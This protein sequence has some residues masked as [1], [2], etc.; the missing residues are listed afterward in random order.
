MNTQ[1]ILNEVD[2]LHASAKSGTVK[3][4]NIQYRLNFNGNNYDV[5]KVTGMTGGVVFVTFNTRS[6]ST[7]KKW[8]KDWLNN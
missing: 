8:L 2:R 4:D 3:I 5:S 7:A 1:K 6:L